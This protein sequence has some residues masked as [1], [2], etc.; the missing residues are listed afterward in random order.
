MSAV[1]NVEID[2]VLPIA[3]MGA[4]LNRLSRQTIKK[5]NIAMTQCNSGSGPDVA[6]VGTDSLRTGAL[7]REGTP[8]HFTCP[9]CGGALWEMKGGKLMRFRCHVGH[10]YTAESLVADQ[11]SGLEAALW[12][13]L[14]ALDEHASLRR[15]MADRARK[16]PMAQIALEYDRQAADAEARAM[17]VRGVLVTDTSAD[18]TEADGAK[19]EAIDA[20]A[21]HTRSPDVSKGANGKV[22][23]VGRS[24][25]G[26]GKKKDPERSNGDEKAVPLKRGAARSR[27]AAA[28]TRRTPLRG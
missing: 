11:A 23:G 28:T 14:R 25:N 19:L 8:S 16:G 18:L 17:L 21:I 2:R 5:G 3:E 12:S 13:A 4:E 15:R 20:K 10:A 1:Q 7:D 26:T 9:E 24:T 22:P 6:E 27:G